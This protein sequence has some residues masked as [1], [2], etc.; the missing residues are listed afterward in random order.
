MHDFRVNALR[1]FPSNRRTVLVG[2]RRTGA[3]FTMLDLVVTLLIIGILAAVSAPRFAGS[4]HRARADSAATR[5]RADLHLARKRAIAASGAQTVQFVP[6]ENLYRLPQ[7]SDLDHRGQMYQV[8]LGQAPYQV[9]LSEVDLGEGQQIVFDHYGMPDRGG[10]ITVRS[11]R[12]E[13]TVTIDAT[14]GR[15][16]TP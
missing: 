16:T 13:Q 6:Q 12:Y 5:I 9:A 7:L 11:G 2:R 4:L 1:A 10:T 3:G 8:L 15:I 14:T